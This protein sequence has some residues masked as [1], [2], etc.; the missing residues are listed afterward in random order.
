MAFEVFYILHSARNLWN[1]KSS[2]AL[3]RL[4][5]EEAQAALETTKSE[6]N[7][8]REELIVTQSSLRNSDM[9][10]RDTE[11]RLSLLSQNR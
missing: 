8:T 2:H 1:T 5:L 6:L 4:Q 10:L 11:R 7:E 3:I 9:Q